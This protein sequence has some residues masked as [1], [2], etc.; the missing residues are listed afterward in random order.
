MGQAFTSLVQRCTVPRQAA[1]SEIDDANTRDDFGWPAIGVG[2]AAVVLGVVLFV[3]ADD[4]HR[5]DRPE[6]SAS[7]S[8]LHSPERLRAM[9]IFWSA[10][11]G[12]GGSIVGTF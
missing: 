6:A 3:T 4:P 8:P 10:P 1:S 9:P 12:G 7:S 2:S 11:G 5:Y